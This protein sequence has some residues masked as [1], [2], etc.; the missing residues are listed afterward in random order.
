MASCDKLATCLRCF[1]VFDYRYTMEKRQPQLV[2]IMPVRSG[3]HMITCLALR[4]DLDVATLACRI[5]K[6]ACGLI[7]AIISSLW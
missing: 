1:L 3:T 5:M 7:S 6:A 4:P 2:R